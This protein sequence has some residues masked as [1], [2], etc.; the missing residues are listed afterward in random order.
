MM[1]LTVETSAPLLA[2]SQPD[3]RI[4]GRVVDAATREPLVGANVFLASTT[5]GDVTDRNGH[6]TIQNIPLG[7]YELIVSLM[8][9]ET[10]KIIVK[11]SEAKNRNFDFTL[12]SKVL[13]GEEV[14]VTGEV[15]KEMKVS[16]FTGQRNL[17]RNTITV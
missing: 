10:Q 5:R 15:P 16:E 3:V 4:T 11:F 2:Q 17:W 13:Q 12:Q 8:G 7:T 9:Y 1:F 6:C 14:T